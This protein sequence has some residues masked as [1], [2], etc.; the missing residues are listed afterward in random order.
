MSDAEQ[1]IGFGQDDKKVMTGGRVERYKGK[2]NHTDRLAIVW[3]FKD[4]EG[5]R[6]M[7]ETDTPKFKM[8]NYHYA[9]GLGY[10]NAKGEYTTQKFGPPK[11]RIGTFVLKYKTD[12]NG[13]LP[14]G[15]DGK[16]QLDFEVLEWQFGEDKYCLLATIHE[17]FPLTAHDIKVTCTDDQYQKLSF[18]ACN[19]QALWQ[20]NDQIR[21]KILERVAEQEHTLSLCRDL[22][23][24]E[25]KQHFGEDTDVVPDVSSDIDYDDLMEDID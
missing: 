21:E 15:A 23:V 9:P 22:S 1:L 2:K 12:R 5:N 8:A 11:R 3:F 16:P 10:I 13:S 20:R 25:I 6:R 14:K 4:E 17:E 24:D 18:T 7:A 19:G